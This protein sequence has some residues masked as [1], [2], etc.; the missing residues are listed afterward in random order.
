MQTYQPA[1]PSAAARVV[2]VTSGKG[3]V[4]KTNVSVNLAIALA[5]MD[6][7]VIVWDMDLGLANVD[8]LLNLKV[9]SNLSD[10][11]AGHRT[12]DEIIV[13][14][15]GGIQVVP[16]ASGDEHL[17]NLGDRA[18][19]FLVR[20]LEYVTEK[21]DFLIIDT[22]AGIAANTTQ[23]TAAADDVI[24]VSTPEP[25]AML[26]AYAMVKL[27]NKTGPQST[28]HFLVNM[29]RTHKEARHAM[30]SMI[31]IAE[32]FIGRHLEEEAFLLYDPAVGD[33]V[34]H[35]RPFVLTN[36]ESEAAHAIRRVAEALV[37]AGPAART[38]LTQT[39]QG[40]FLHRLLHRLSGTS[41]HA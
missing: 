33:A 34:R 19:H 17:A 8:I 9:D 12:I 10:V 3:G 23:F 25:T 20:A 13:T 40:G 38:P 28:I 27:V 30:L 11:L 26:D 6:R 35:R 37:N 22:G 7:R 36:P 29:A 2:A 15:P 24:V 31:S 16:G 18:R 32:G 39:E 1:K 4:G 21:A 41:L 14:G 5:Q